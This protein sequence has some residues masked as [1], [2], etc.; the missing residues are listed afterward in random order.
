MFR[1]IESLSARHA[2]LLLA[3]LVAGATPLAAQREGRYGLREVRNLG[4]AG[5]TLVL[6]VPQGEFG[7]NVD[8]AGGL[9]LFVA[10]ALGAG[11]PLSFRLDGSYLIYGSQHQ[12][13]PQ[14]YYPL[15]VRTI[16]SIAT[17]GAGPQLTLGGD[18]PA[19]LYGFGTF[20]VSYIWAHSSYD[21]GGCGCYPSASGIDFDDW[22]T[23]LQGG[24]GLLL[25]L[26]RRRT[27]ISLDLG[28]RYLR[29]AT[30]WYVSPGDVQLQPNGDL[31]VYPTHSRADL[32]LVHVGVS[33]GLR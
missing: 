3:L 18:S 8:V 23:A 1:T 26:N 17:L 21:A 28:V 22:T 25:T 30:A 20:G 16:Y 11:S 5:A 9:N 13:V 27:P 7:R 31:M 29:N 2:G 4:S 19:R 12:F 33:I 14:S 24:G 6:G 15:D 32:L 10:P